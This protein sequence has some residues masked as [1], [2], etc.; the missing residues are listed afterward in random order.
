MKNIFYFLEGNKT[1]ITGV[2]TAIVSLLL[3]FEFVHWNEKQ[4]AAI[5]AFLAALFGMSFRSAMKTETKNVVQSNEVTQ[6]K[7]VKLTNAIRNQY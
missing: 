7:T 4:I 5:Y 6:D 1:Y 3:V 2:A